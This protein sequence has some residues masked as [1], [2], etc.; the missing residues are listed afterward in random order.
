MTLLKS[1]V[2]RFFSFSKVRI[3]LRKSSVSLE[4]TICDYFLNDGL[5]AGKHNPYKF[6][7]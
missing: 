1:V 4:A 7:T 3:S 5:V 6:S 2:D